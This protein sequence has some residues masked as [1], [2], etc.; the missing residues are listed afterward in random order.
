MKW[1]FMFDSFSLMAQFNR[2]TKNEMI[3]I[4]ARTHILAIHFIHKTSFRVCFFFLKSEFAAYRQALKESWHCRKILCAAVFMVSIRFFTCQKI[5]W[6]LLVS[7]EM[8]SIVTFFISFSCEQHEQAVCI[9]MPLA[10]HT[11]LFIGEKG[12]K[13]QILQVST[14]LFINPMLSFFVA[15]NYIRTILLCLTVC[16]QNKTT[17]EWLCLCSATLPIL[18]VSFLVIMQHWLSFHSMAKAKFYEERKKK[19]TGEKARKS[20]SMTK[21]KRFAAGKEQRW[22]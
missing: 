15:E 12:G 1:R 13:I 14:H 3:L 2:N 17:V 4:S 22:V 16:N 7:T 19:R 6:A 9:C 11:F 18:F 5:K 20:T 10:K 21:S 8:I